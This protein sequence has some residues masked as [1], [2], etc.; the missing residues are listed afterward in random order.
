MAE[1]G[2]AAAPSR[3][4][5]TSQVEFHTFKKLEMR[6]PIHRSQLT[7]DMRALVEDMIRYRRQHARRVARATTPAGA[8][9]CCG[10][11]AAAAPAAILG[12]I[13]GGGGVAPEPE[14]RNFIV[15]Q[16]HSF[17]PAIRLS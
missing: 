13:P 14:I 15:L 2:D 11:Q 10:L 12:T 6:P 9:S 5:W 3:A 7:G 16:L 17:S 4:F 8:A 1:A